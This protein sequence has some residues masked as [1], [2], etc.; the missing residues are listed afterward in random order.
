LIEV[1]DINGGANGPECRVRLICHCGAPRL[2]IYSKVTDRIIYCA[3]CGSITTL[4]RLRREWADDPAAR[5]EWQLINVREGDECPLVNVFVPVR[6]VFDVGDRKGC[7][8]QGVLTKLSINKA[9]LRLKEYEEGDP[10]APPSLAKGQYLR[11]EGN[12]GPMKGRTLACIEDHVTPPTPDSPVYYKLRFELLMP[13]RREE[14]E[15][16]YR[17]ACG[18]TTRADGTPRVQS[19]GRARRKVELRPPDTEPELDLEEAHTPRTPESSPG[20]PAPPEESRLLVFGRGLNGATPNGAVQNGAAAN[21]VLPGAAGSP[22]EPEWPAEPEDEPPAVPMA[23][24]TNDTLGDDDPAPRYAPRPAPAQTPVRPVAAEPRVETTAPIAA[25]SLED[26]SI[27]LL[28]LTSETHDQNISNH[29]KRI[30]SY[31]AAIARELNWSDEAAARL[32]TASKL[33]DLGKIGVPDQILKKT[34][35]LTEEERTTMQQHTRLGYHILENSASEIMRLGAVIALRH[36]ERYDGTGYPDGLVGDAIPIEAQIVSIADVF[37]AL[38]TARPY[39]PAWPTDK[40]V[41]YIVD[42]AGKMFNP[43]VVD[44]FLKAMPEIKRNQLRFIDDFRDIWTERRNATR[45]PVA[46]V[47]IS[48]EVAMPEMTFRPYRLEGIICNLS[49]YGVK[50][51]L[52]NVTGDMFGL[53]VN[54]RRY[55]KIY[56]EQPL[57]EPLHQTFCRVAWIDYYALPDPDACLMGLE[58]QNPI[59]ELVEIIQEIGTAPQPEGV[60]GIERIDSAG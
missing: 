43:Q 16:F 1:L 47:P 6:L 2:A 60:E 10:Q 26:D 34:G 7:E 50:A 39:K 52:N 21:G 59:H 9:F 29:L 35:A 46:P 23:N 18:L 4:T 38:T 20:E 32:A 12:D 44:A 19:N 48:I 41:Q 49:A 53:L 14:L 17:E 42:Q 8:S 58:F 22:P 31:S 28:I 30:S 57:W 25:A 11:L 33:H 45:V 27:R 3:N 37:D 24:A 51:R 54:S 56:C 15:K 55:A 13:R 40:T 5:G 36:H